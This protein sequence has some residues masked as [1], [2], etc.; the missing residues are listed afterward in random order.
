MKITLNR[1]ALESHS[2]SNSYDSV[3]SEFGT[4][5]SMDAETLQGLKQS[6]KIIAFSLGLTKRKPR[7]RAS[8][9]ELPLSELNEIVAKIEADISS[10][11]DI[12]MYEVDKSGPYLAVCKVRAGYA[13]YLVTRR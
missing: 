3:I 9:V 4:F 8:K 1:G 12:E 2:S 6:G 11:Q 13:G 5:A 10:I 7:F